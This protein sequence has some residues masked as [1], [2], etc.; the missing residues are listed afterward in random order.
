[1]SRIKLTSLLCFFPFILFKNI[2]ILNWSSI[3]RAQLMDAGI[4][5]LINSTGVEACEL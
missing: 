5:F 2:H 4:G 1:M 3:N